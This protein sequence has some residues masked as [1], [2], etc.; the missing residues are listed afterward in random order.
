MVGFPGYV[1]EGPSQAKRY[2]FP[3]SAWIWQGRRSES[4]VLI[5]FRLGSHRFPA[6]GILVSSTRVPGSIFHDGWPYGTAIRLSE[7]T[8]N[9]GRPVDPRTLCDGEA[10]SLSW[11]LK[12]HR[13]PGALPSVRPGNARLDG[14]QAALEANVEPKTT[15]YAFLGW[16]GI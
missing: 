8:G 16:D 12:D 10:Q 6:C 3:P 14:R 11:V 9:S 4:R 13:S 15:G 1:C 5:R 2:S 7:L